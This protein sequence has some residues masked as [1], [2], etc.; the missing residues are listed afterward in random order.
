MKSNPFVSSEKFTLGNAI[1]LR[2]GDAAM[3][4]KASKD[5]KVYTEDGQYT[6]RVKL[7]DEFIATR[8]VPGKFYFYQQGKDGKYFLEFELPPN[9]VVP[10]PG[11]VATNPS[12]VGGP[13]TD[14]SL[15]DFEHGFK[16]MVYVRALKGFTVDS[17][18]KPKRYLR[19][20]SNEVFQC[21]DAH[22]LEKYYYFDVLNLEAIHHAH[23][24][25]HPYSFRFVINR[26]LVERMRD[27]YV[28]IR[29][30]P[31]VKEADVV[32]AWLNDEGISYTNHRGT[33]VYTPENKMLYS[34][35][36]PLAWKKDGNVMYREKLSA[37]GKRHLGMVKPLVTA[38]YGTNSMLAVKQNPEPIDIKWAVRYRV[39]NGVIVND[40]IDE[41]AYVDLNN[42][43][44]A[45]KAEILEAKPNVKLNPD[46]SYVE[47]L[48]LMKMCV[49][50]SIREA[51]VGMADNANLF[52]QR[53][54][55]LYAHLDSDEQKKR[56]IKTLQRRLEKVS[57]RKGTKVC[58]NPRPT[59]EHEGAFDVVTS[60]IEAAGL[61]MQ[62]EQMAKAY[63]YLQEAAENLKLLLDEMGYNSLTI[64][65]VE[66][67]NEMRME[68]N[69]LNSPPRVSLIRPEVDRPDDTSR[70]IKDVR[71]DKIHHGI[72]QLRSQLEAQRVTSNPRPLFPHE[73]VREIQDRTLDRFAGPRSNL[74][75][76]W[77]DVERNP[78]VRVSNTGNGSP[79]LGHSAFIGRHDGCASSSFDSSELELGIHEEMEHT[80]D[81]IIAEAIAKDHLAEDPQ[82]YSKLQSA[83]GPPSR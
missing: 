27:D 9:S 77:E 55:E 30:N 38:K 64:P 29:S 33:L 82:Y 21:I 44:A 31:Q 26:E 74:N 45:G 78:Q 8:T 66:S 79:L 48:K 49:K 83:F 5:F 6:L 46:H 54:A 11:H 19:V 3:T 39:A 22:P 61:A 63:S 73:V 56:E 76:R 18:D 62:A 34:H 72:A 80:D 69:K 13:S 14:L 51:R 15:T 37:R 43:E 23:S 68:Y 10:I 36:E 7:G 81:A 70:Y 32:N 2:D 4:V 28:P 47:I 1:E 53:F 65:L 35:G 60:A 58:T 75:E 42:Q 40:V 41:S 57:V 67:Y 12:M 20:K 71:L 52:K 24:E 17:G 16:K 59:E 50:N 25:K